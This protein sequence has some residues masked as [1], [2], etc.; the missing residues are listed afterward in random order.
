MFKTIQGKELNETLWRISPNLIG[1]WLH[2]TD[3]L[4]CK[5]E[6]DAQFFPDFM[7]RR[8]QKKKKDDSK[9]DFKEDRRKER[10]NY[11]SLKRGELCDY[12][13]QNCKVSSL[14]SGFLFAALVVSLFFNAH[15]GLTMFLFA[16]FNLTLRFGR[17][18][19]GKQGKVFKNKENLE[20]DE[21][22]ESIKPKHI[23]F[24]VKKTLP[25]R[26]VPYTQHSVR[27]HYSQNQWR[28][29][30]SYHLRQGGRVRSLRPVEGGFTDDSRHIKDT[31]T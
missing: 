31:G 7:K 28:Y 14:I 5:T 26:M 21:D 1:V 2:S 18:E 4:F 12:L 6:V 10:S 25:I 13:E 11:I 15:S 8:H 17:R 22:E 27:S 29:E 9:E 20:T 23:R 16:L 3:S 30:D 24:D 19:V